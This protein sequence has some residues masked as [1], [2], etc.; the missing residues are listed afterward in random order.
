MFID[1][2]QYD[3]HQHR[4]QNE[5]RHGNRSATP[6]SQTQSDV[7]NGIAGTGARKTLSK[8]DNFGEIRI[9]YPAALAN[10]GRADLREDGD[11]TAKA[12]QSDFK[13]R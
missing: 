11:A 8:S 13:K 6:T 3:H 12:N 5:T 10:S 9:G 2:C 7:S 1:D 4:R